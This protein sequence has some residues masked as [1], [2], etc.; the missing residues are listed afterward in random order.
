[1]LTR[2]DTDDLHFEGD[3]G[4]RWIPNGPDDYDIEPIDAI[5]NSWVDDSG[6]RHA[7]I[8]DQDQTERWV[9]RDGILTNVSGEVF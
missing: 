2:N 4:V 6:V 1:M 9:M 3:G 8:F 5:P 7:V